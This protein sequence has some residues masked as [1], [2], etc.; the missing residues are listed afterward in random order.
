MERVFG[1]KEIDFKFATIILAGGKSSR[2][3]RDKTFLPLDSKI[4]FLER[5]LNLAKDLNSDDL[6]VSG[7]DLED[8]YK[9]MGPLS[10]FHSALTYYI[11]KNYQY[12]LFIPVD[13]PR[14]S[15]KTLTL[16]LNNCDKQSALHFIGFEM[17][18]LVKVCTT[19]LEILSFILN[20]DSDLSVRNF[21]N[22]IDAKKIL[23]PIEKLVE[24]KNINTP[25]EYECEIFSRISSH[26]S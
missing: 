8:L 6:L 26:A 2:M 20:E 14:L 17:P 3:G 5:A 24:F 16:L 13:M 23:L 9:S 22:Q 7:R 11:D 4:S 18:V 10:G 15:S 1:L 12:L 19:N 25:E 21:L